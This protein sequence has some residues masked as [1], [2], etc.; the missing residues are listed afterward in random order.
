MC[1]WPFIP[2][3]TLSLLFPVLCLLI[4]VCHG[5]VVVA[6]GVAAVAA[7]ASSFIACSPA[8]R[9]V[10]EQCT[11]VTNLSAGMAFWMFEAAPRAHR[12]N[13]HFG[14]LSSKFALA[15]L[16]LQPKFQPKSFPFFCHKL[17]QRRWDRIC[18]RGEYSQ[19][20]TLRMIGV[21]RMRKSRGWILFFGGR[22][23]HSRAPKP[24]PRSSFAITVSSSICQPC[25]LRSFFGKRPSLLSLDT[26]FVR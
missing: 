24:F 15:S 4:C 14:D 19:N 11:R 23:Q 2:C 9:S 3:G 21:L 18:G 25:T 7:G 26:P 1:I 8:S 6:A 22:A 13:P 12:T 10:P 20:T 5:G 16:T 17:K